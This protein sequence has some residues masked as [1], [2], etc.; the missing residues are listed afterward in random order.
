M[1]VYSVLF[2]SVVIGVAE[3]TDGGWVGRW[4]KSFEISLLNGL[5][6]VA[7]TVGFNDVEDD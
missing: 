1:L 6:G 4:P 7:D 5:P 3:S 2:S